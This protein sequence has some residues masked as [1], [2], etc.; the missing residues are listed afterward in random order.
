MSFAE[1]DN[2]VDAFRRIVPISFSAYPSARA[3]QAHSAP[4][5]HGA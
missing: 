2:A 3:S 5:T 4:N 1:R